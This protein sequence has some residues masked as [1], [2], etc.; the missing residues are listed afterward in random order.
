MKNIVQINP[1]LDNK[2]FKNIFNVT[3]KTY[4]TENK[5]TIK[6]EKRIKNKLKPKF[7]TTYSNWTCGLYACLKILNLKPSDEVIVPN[8]T[9]IAT[10]NSVLMA[11]LRPVLC[12]IDNDSLCIDLNKIKK[13][14]TKKTKV[15][16]PVHLYGN[17]CDMDKLIKICKDRNITIIED[18]AQAIG[19]KYKKKFLGTLGDFGGISFYGNKIITTGEGGAVF[20]KKKSNYKKLYELK[21]HGRSKKG[22]FKHNSIGFNFMFTEMQAAIGNEQIK[23]LDKILKKKEFIYKYYNKNLKEIDK[24]SF[25]KPTKNC[26]PVYWFSNIFVKEKTKLINYLKSKKIQTRESFFPLNEQPCFKNHK[27]IKNLKKNYPVS[28][29]IY[30]TLISLPSSFDL[31]KRQ[32]DYIILNIKSF[33]AKKYRN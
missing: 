3:K 6:F 31:T 13:C 19:S 2:E 9:F 27:N 25:K 17:S 4:L 29:R 7:I 24:I 22:I 30:N 26:E 14:I 5:E 20:C 16:I 18:S 32:L 1:Y 23:K 12:E 33:Y 10:I 28:K 11:N 21:N 8:L 15:I